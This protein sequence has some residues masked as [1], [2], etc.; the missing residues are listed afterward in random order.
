MRACS[1]APNA[2]YL[3][4]TRRQRAVGS[5]AARKLAA[6]A[7]YAANPLRTYI[8]VD[9]F[10]LYNRALKNTNHKWLDLRALCF[11]LLSPANQILAIKYYTARVSGDRDPDQPRRQQLYFN[12]LET[13]PEVSIY[14]GKFL[15]KTIRRP[16]VTPI[17]G[18]PRFVEVHT[19]EEKGSDVNLA[20]HLVRDGFKNL[21]DV[22][23]VL[24]KD[25]DL[26][27]P[28]RIVRHELGKAIGM[29]CPD[30]DA[31][32]PLREVSSFVRHIT[33]SRLSASQFPNPVIAPD[34][35]RIQKPA[36]WK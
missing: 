23:V 36:T 30:N 18:L 28:M 35:Q 25:T 21:F 33:P 29:I 9:G 19:V 6:F 26:V 7:F 1:R 31:P 10:N 16:L 24:S 2:V 4:S 32:K 5:K 27:E 8:Y 17:P 22:A 11:H 15:P 12:A 20:S 34:G 3:I 14:Y 13:L